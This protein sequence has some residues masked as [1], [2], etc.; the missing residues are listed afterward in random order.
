LSDFVCNLDNLFIIK[1]LFIVE[2]VY[3]LFIG[4]FDEFMLV[5]KRSEHTGESV[6]FFMCVFESLQAG[7]YLWD[8]M[9]DFLM[10]FK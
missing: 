7:S 8:L 3:E 2:S 9:G 6:R 10:L 1:S 5:G 4:G